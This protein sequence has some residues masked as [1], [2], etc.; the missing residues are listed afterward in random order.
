MS[1][2]GSC[3]LNMSN[4]KYLF[5]FFFVKHFAMVCPNKYNLILSNSWPLSCNNG[6][7]V[8]CALD[9]GWKKNAG[10]S[11]N[12]RSVWYSTS[13]TTSAT[14]KQANA[15]L[16]PSVLN[17]GLQTTGLCNAT[18]RVS[19]KLMKGKRFQM[20]CVD[21]HVRLVS[22]WVCSLFRVKSSTLTR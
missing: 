10:A 17:Q 16:P 4:K 6:C 13:P 20:Y 1:R 12:D 8:G 9:T 21:P 2:T 15:I 19:I 3:Y 7:Q 11:A 22:T 18:P 5:S 14:F